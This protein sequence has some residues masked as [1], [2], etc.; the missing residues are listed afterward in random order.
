MAL[1]TWLLFVAAVLVLTITPGPSVLMCISTS[2]QYGPRRALVASVGST[3]AIAC[4]MLLSML[5]LGTV[6]AASETLF[7]ALKWLGAGYLAYLGITSLLAKASNLSVPKS[8]ASEL[9]TR[10][11]FTRGLFVGASNPKALLFFGALFPQFIDPSAPQLI[12]FIVL[13]TTFI[14]FELFWLSV[15]AI[16]AARARTWLQKPRRATL[17]NRITGVVFLAAAGLL[18]TTRRNAA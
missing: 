5:G 8:N 12:Q 2:V 6:L 13:G 1:S 17:F 4:I 7:S 11:L 14:F 16:T 18:A 15:Y 3:I 9:S 10:S